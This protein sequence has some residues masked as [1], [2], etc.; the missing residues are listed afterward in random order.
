MIIIIAK[1]INYCRKVPLAI[2]VILIV[3][4]CAGSLS[5][6]RLITAASKYQP[7]KVENLSREFWMRI[8]SRVSL[9]YRPL[10]PGSHVESQENKKLCFCTASLALNSC[11]GEACHA[12]TK[13]FI[14]LRLNMALHDKGLLM[15][16]LYNF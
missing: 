8:W 6:M 2:K 1:Q 9:I 12:K 14:L 10:L 7:D 11:L 15:S 5:A 16:S 13:L 4:H 3:N